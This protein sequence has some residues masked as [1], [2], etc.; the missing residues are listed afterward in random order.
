MSDDYHRPTLTFPSGAYN[1]TQ[2]R[3]YGIAPG[4]GDLVYPNHPKNLESADFAISVRSQSDDVSQNDQFLQQLSDS[5]VTKEQFLNLIA[6]RRISGFPDEFGYAT[7]ISLAVRNIGFIVISTVVSFD[8]AY[9]SGKV[10]SSGIIVGYSY[11]GHCFDLPK[12][13]I[14]LLPVLPQMIPLDDCGYDKK[15]NRQDE[16][17]PEKYMLWI[18]DKLDECVEFEM[19]QGFIEQIVLDANLPGKR[20]PTMYASKMT[21]GHRGGKLTE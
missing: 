3:L 21:M 20:S 7:Q 17:G 15:F 2:V 12:P 1:A 10:L 4:G 11:E 9:N 8:E 6:N 5:K 18:V 16:N 14:M 19:N 13:K